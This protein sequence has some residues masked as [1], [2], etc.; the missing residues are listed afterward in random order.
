MYIPGELY[1]RLKEFELAATHIKY[2][3]TQWPALHYACSLV[4]VLW[5]GVFSPPIVLSSKRTAAKLSTDFNQPKTQRALVQSFLGNHE[6]VGTCT[7]F[8]GGPCEIVAILIMVQLGMRNVPF[9]NFLVG[10][11][12]LFPSLNPFKHNCWPPKFLKFVQL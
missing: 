4:L 7:Y 3:T 1:L 11:L 9:T 12:L 6:E 2:V 5:L 10:N 8:C